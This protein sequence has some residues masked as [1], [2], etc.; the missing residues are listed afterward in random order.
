[1]PTNI[2]DSKLEKVEKDIVK[3]LNT[4]ETMCN[5]FLSQLDYDKERLIDERDSSDQSIFETV[6]FIRRRLNVLAVY[7][8]FDKVDNQSKSVDQQ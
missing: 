8:L 5:F 3:E 1:L 4:F 7:L 6:N 2:R